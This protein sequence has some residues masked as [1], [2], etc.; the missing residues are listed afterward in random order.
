MIKLKNI[1]DF[2]LIKKEGLFYNDWYINKYLRSEKL[3]NSLLWKL[4]DMGVPVISSLSRAITNPIWHYIA[5]G[6]SGKFDPNPFFDS[7]IYLKNNSNIGVMKI[8]PLIHYLKFRKFNLKY[9]PYST[10]YFEYIRLLKKLNVKEFLLND[11]L[12]KHNHISDHF[13]I[14]VHI[15]LHY[16][17]LSNYFIKKLKN[18]TQ[19]FDLFIS[20][21]SNNNEKIIQLFKNNLDYVSKLVVKTVPNR[22]R[23]FSAL[24]IGFGKELVNYDILL[25]IHSKKSAHNPLF[26]NWLDH[27]MNH[28]CGNKNAVTNIVNLFNK[29]AVAVYAEPF[30][31]VAGDSSSWKN[32]KKIAKRLL[33]KFSNISINNLN[34]I[35]F[36]V[37]GMFWIKPKA[38]RSLF[39]ADIKFTDFSNEPLPSDGTLAHAIERIILLLAKEK[40]SGYCY[41][42]V[43]KKTIISSSI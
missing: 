31:S 43:S 11:L 2:F 17:D 40:T 35:E 6:N 24:V 16:F 42:I 36:P 23:N 27:I 18:I 30:S 33:S 14:A 37:G 41:K 39:K 7:I 9:Y 3:D 32:N 26:N 12:K 34:V 5:N 1:S 15:H 25:H 28:L 13:K 19:P 10:Y 4:R 21:N 22:G 20:T 38:I 29:D 8:N